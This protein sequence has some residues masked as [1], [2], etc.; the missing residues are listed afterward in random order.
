MSNVHKFTENA[1]KIT[2]KISLITDNMISINERKE[3]DYRPYKKVP[4][5]TRDLREAVKI[6]LGEFFCEYNEGDYAYVSVSILS[7]KATTVAVL[8]DG[9]ECIYLNGQCYNLEETEV[10]FGKRN[11]ELYLRKGYNTLSFKCVAKKDTFKMEYTVG[12]V[13]WPFL[14]TCDYL[15][16]VRD[17]IPVDEYVGEQGMAISELIKKDEN[18]SLEESK[19]IYPNKAKDDSIVDFE[20]LY[21]E[22]KG[23]YVLSLS[24]AKANGIIEIITKNS[25]IKI[26]INK[27]LS[28]NGT[29]VNAGDEI[30]VISKRG[31]TG[32]GFECASN[33]ILYLPFVKSERN[34]GTHWI[35]IG[36]FADG[37]LKDI[38]FTSTYVTADNS[39]TYWRFTEEDTYLRPYLDTSFYGQWFYGLMVGEYGLLR[40]SEYNVEY[41]KYF[42]DSMRILVDYFKY[43]KYDAKMFGTST[44]LKRSVELP[45]L[46]SIGT[47]GMNLCELYIRTEDQKYREKIRYVLDNLVQA[48]DKNIVKMTDGTFY[49][50]TTM[51]LDDTYMSC[52][53]LVRMGNLTGVT[54][55]YDEAIK[56]LKLYTQKLF[57]KEWNVFAHIFWPLEQRNNNIP[58][59][60]GNGWGYLS[61]AEVIE[62]LPE[63]YNGRDE[64]IDIFKEAVDG[65]IKLQDECGMWHQVLNMKDSYCE[66]SCTALFAIAISKGIKL[67]IFD[68]ES[69]LPIIKKAVNG[70]MEYGVDECGNVLNVCRGSGCCDSAEYYAQLKTII[71][72]DHG[73]GVVIAALCE[74]KEQIS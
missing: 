54:K 31:E 58:W 26:Y 33:N 24:Y 6:N 29:K 67:G 57:M 18:K 68:K 70:V 61:F 51:W 9:V 45:D 34:T 43:M 21:A 73:V 41:Y 63:D 14:W 71:N 17:C 53:F 22:E 65:L 39:M 52:P 3:I 44:F 25:E 11:I 55:Y 37:E 19:I 5:V 64:L 32:W 27:V 38:Q 36:A 2:E 20:K 48:I 15:L 35:H 13:S 74:L 59:G 1:K 4:F 49:R 40:A 12:H 42:E 46:D 56:Q 7:Q 60:R 28:Q 69:Y 30:C 8:V 72:D 16:W 47:I 23:E 66:T 50:H 62:H 10:A